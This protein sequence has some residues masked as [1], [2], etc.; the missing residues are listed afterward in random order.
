MR[1]SNLIFTAA[2]L[3][4]ICCLTISVMRAQS[5]SPSPA[6]VT[7]QA[8]QDDPERKEAFAL[9]EQHKMAEA[10]PLLEK[11]VARYAN[12]TAA[13]EHLGVALVSRS[14]TWTEPEKQK[15]DLLAARRELL[16]AREL[17][18]NSPLCNVLLGQIPEDGIM[19][20][21]SARAEVDA[22]IKRG[23]AA[24]ANNDLDT[25]LK[26]YTAAYELDPSL[27]STALYI[28]DTYFQLKQTEKAGEWFARAI[29]IN[30]NRE[31]AYRYWGDALMAASRV[32]EARTKFMEAVVAW[33]YQQIAWDGLNQWVRKNNLQYKDVK[34]NL[35]KGPSANDKGELNITIDP[36]S[37]ETSGG[38]AWMAYSME[39]ALWS[40]EKFKKE[41]PD[42]KTYRHSLK[43]EVAALSVAVS[44]YQETA[45]ARSK[46]KGKKPKASAPDPQL[47]LLVRLKAAGMLEPF[48]LFMHPDQGIA[49]DYEAF[50]AAHRNKLMEFLDKY[51]VPEAP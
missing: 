46:D 3:A 14:S 37:M 36:G 11:V 17:G 29:Q 26:E 47:E 13:H 31:T 18:D 41:F 38:P 30:Q 20:P 21:F 24:F 32:K 40:G 12:D 33:P 39:R 4:V 35:P 23:E 19:A 16:R 25:A 7:E 5:P 34:V 50:Q 10:V 9:F 27:Y 28:G 8:N 15:A 6:K 49:R 51:L 48:V 45:D 1:Q 42:E 2:A 43:E 44:V 22:A